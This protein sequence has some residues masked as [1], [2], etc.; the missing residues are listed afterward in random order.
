MEESSRANI[1]RILEEALKAIKED[2]IKIIRDLSN[3]TLHSASI[4]QDADNIGIAVLMYSLSKILERTDYRELEGWKRCMQIMLEKIKKAES[5]LKQYKYEVFRQ[6]LK[7]ILK[8]VNHLDPRLKKNI[9][10][11]FDIAKINKAS[12]L[13]EHGISIGRTAELLGVSKWELM[14]YA[15]KT[16]ISEKVSGINVIERIKYA[17]SLFK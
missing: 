8:E 1:L 13:Y 16:G 2:D 4:F 9:Q 14:D 12:R 6:E 10:E 17:K 11:V 5:A 15:G 7:N 3:Q